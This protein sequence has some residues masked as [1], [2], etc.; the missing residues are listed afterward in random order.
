MPEEADP[1]GE[2]AM[3]EVNSKLNQPQGY[4]QPPMQAPQKK[5]HFRKDPEAEKIKE[6]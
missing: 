3:N 4:E 6:L 5:A 1:S 2:A